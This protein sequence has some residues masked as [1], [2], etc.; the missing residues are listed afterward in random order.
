MDNNS[1]SPTLMKLAATVRRHRKRAELTQLQL[2][3]LI[4]CS[5]RTI[6]AIETGRE[7]P[8]REMVVAVERALGISPDALV[9]LYDLLDAESLPGWMRD[10]VLE[11]RRATRLRSFELV[12]IPGLLQTEGYA[13]ALLNGNETLVE[14]RMDRQRILAS[15]APP[16][17]HVVLDEAAMY[18][19]V[20]GRQDMFDQLEHL[21]QCVSEKLTVQIVPSD[22]NPCHIGAFMIGTIDGNGDVAYIETAVRGIVTSSRNDVTHLNGTWEKIRSH[23]LSQRESLHFIRRTA[24]ER[25]A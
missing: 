13:R 5:D 6:S 21:I 15:D 19:E 11:E 23:A 7:R 1:P 4:P 8:S 18:R 25:W 24:E 22:V 2:A 14:A 17:L 3:E 10:W 20:G 16:T 9:D 12:I